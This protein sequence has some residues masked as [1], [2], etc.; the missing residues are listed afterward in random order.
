MHKYIKEKFPSS[1]NGKVD[2]AIPFIF[3]KIT[4]PSLMIKED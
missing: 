2:L 4:N 3:E 1:K